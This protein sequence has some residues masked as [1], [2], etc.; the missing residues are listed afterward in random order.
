MLTIEQMDRLRQV[1]DRIDR[2]RDEIAR[3][4][5]SGGNDSPT[6]PDCNVDILLCPH[7]HQ[8]PF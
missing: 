2:E 4:R 7:S 3:A 6:P 1:I 5:M 8:M